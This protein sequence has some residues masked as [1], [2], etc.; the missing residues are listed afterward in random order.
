MMVEPTRHLIFI[1][2]SFACDHQESSML[3]PWLD[4]GVQVRQ[5]SATTI[6]SDNSPTPSDD[7]CFISRAHRRQQSHSDHPPISHPS[8][9]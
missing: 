5:Q 1:S 2:L 3:L 7:L 8:L 4:I 6:C 9:L